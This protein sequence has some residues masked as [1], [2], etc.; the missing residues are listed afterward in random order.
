MTNA[1]ITGEVRQ[2]AFFSLLDY[3]SQPALMLI[4]A[5]VL[6]RHL[7]IEQYGAWMFVNTVIA[8]MCGLGGGF[9]EA[10]TRYVSL[11]RG[12]SDGQGIARSLIAVLSINCMV[13]FLLLVA[14]VIGAPILADHLFKVQ[15]LSL[16]TVV[17]VLRIG[18]VVLWFRI[19]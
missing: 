1:H 18:A 12:R 3:L 14:L 10:A 15:H 5:P 2:N 17:A 19:M 8:V 16:P 13:G 11:Y 4:A 9:G 7:G 6:L